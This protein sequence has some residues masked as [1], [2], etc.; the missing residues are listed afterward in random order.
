MIDR[1]GHNELFD[2]ANVISERDESILRHIQQCKYMTTG[3]IQRVFYTES[4]SSRSAL[5]LANRELA[6]LRDRS[7]IQSLE[8][9]IGGIRGG[10]GTYIWTLTQTG[11]RLL[12]FKD[13]NPQKSRSRFQEPSLIFLTHTLAITELDVL[14][15]EMAKTTSVELS[16]IQHEPNCWRRYMGLHG[17]SSCLRP[18][19]LAI[20]INEEYVDHWFFEVDLA[21][22]TPACVVRKCEQYLGYYRSGEE[23]K[24]HGVFPRVVWIVP[25]NKRK[26]I[27]QKHIRGALPQRVRD[28]FSVIV[29]DEFAGLITQDLTEEKA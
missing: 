22:E 4:S 16:C 21:T 15:R 27:L 29:M 9:R 10:S 13:G 3:Q 26:N 5:R 11:V 17:V 8:R 24:A 7:L 18:D 20:T 19:L 23:Q 1:T 25:D 2:L 6:R 14:L 12:A 28:I